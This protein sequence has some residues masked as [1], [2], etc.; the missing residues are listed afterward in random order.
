MRRENWE[1]H[2]DALMKDWQ[3]RPFV[4]GQADCAQF[5][6]AVLRAVSGRDWAQISVQPYKTARGARALLQRL[7]AGDMPAL[8]DKML[9]PRMPISYAQRG[10]IVSAACR[11][12]P[13]L[14]VCLGAHIA[15]PG[16]D[17]LVYRP[18]SS[19]FAAW[20]I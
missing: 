3:S 8:A 12:G 9:G 5:A 7:E 15:L 20:R 18:L 2:L 11:F 14:G 19:A 16:E 10:D 1:Q 6:L 13:A 17:G 4:W